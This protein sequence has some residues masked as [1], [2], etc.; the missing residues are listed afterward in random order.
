MLVLL[1]GILLTLPRRLRMERRAR[2]LLR[3]YPNAERTSIYVALH[4]FWPASRTREIDAKIDEMKSKGWSFLRGREASPFQTIRSF[5]G[6]LTLHFF[7]VNHRAEVGEMP[8]R[9]SI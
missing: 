9:S 1:I 3:E 6:G 5:G 8:L 2:S 4:S 7:R